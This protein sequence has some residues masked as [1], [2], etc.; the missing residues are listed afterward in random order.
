MLI[1]LRWKGLFSPYL[2][3]ML[4]GSRSE[5]F[6]NKAHN[7]NS[8]DFSC[9]AAVTAEQEWDGVKGRTGDEDV[10]CGSSAFRYK[11]QCSGQG[12]PA[13]WNKVIF[14]LSVNPGHINPARTMRS[15]R[16]GWILT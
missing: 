8:F 2:A 13:A 6:R 4:L 15:G 3:V 1:Q 12:R 11:D 16:L 14:C 5:S 9:C 7:S 10:L